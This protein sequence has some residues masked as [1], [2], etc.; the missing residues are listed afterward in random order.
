MNL[1]LSH[2]LKYFPIM[3]CTI[4]CLCCSES[5]DDNNPKG[6]YIYRLHNEYMFN[7][8]EPKKNDHKIFAWDDETI[9]GIPKITKE[10]FRCRG[11]LLNPDKDIVVNNENIKISDCGGIN[12]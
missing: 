2:M 8:P 3:L 10:F 5:R 6:E 4:L 7:P 9:D 12:K 1:T 11:N